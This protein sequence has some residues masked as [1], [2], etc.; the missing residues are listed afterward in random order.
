[1]ERLSDELPDEHIAKRWIVTSDPEEAVAEIR[2]YVDWGFDHL[3]IHAPAP[4]RVL[5][6]SVQRRRPSAPARA[7]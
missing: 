7:G 4:T 6:R 2:Q 1:M 3:V 5:P